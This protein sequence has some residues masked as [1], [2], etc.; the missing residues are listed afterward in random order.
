MNT[1]CIS[2]KNLP[3]VLYNGIMNKEIND[4]SF[5]EMRKWMTKSTYCA[6]LVLKC[7]HNFREDNWF[8]ERSH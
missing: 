4:Y 5:V 7:S 2:Q 1:K 8:G 6:V 3:V